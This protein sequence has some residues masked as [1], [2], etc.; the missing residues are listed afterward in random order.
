MFVSNET[1][2]I[3]DIKRIVEVV[4]GK[5]PRTILHI[6]AVQGFCKIPLNI[7][8]LDIDALSI[9]A[10]KFHGPKGV[11]A[12]YVKNE[13]ALKPLIIGGGQERGYRSGTENLAGIM[14]MAKACENIDIKKN[15]AN[16]IKLCDEFLQEIDFEYVN[17]IKTDSPYILSMSFKDV[18]GETLMRALENEVII[19][20]GSACSTKKA[21][22]RILDAMGFDKDYIKS[23]V[24]VSFNAYQT[25]EEVRNAGK[26][27]MKKYLEILEKVK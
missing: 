19:G 3:N 9:S 25:L 8:E 11:G 15:F 12:L 1:G 22:N 23:S 18:N 27:I 5:N 7:G 20:T 16:T 2:A 13:S 21:G 6:D 4:K 17:V 10:H 26:I 24:R 14:C